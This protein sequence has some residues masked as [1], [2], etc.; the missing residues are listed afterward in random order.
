MEKDLFIYY[1][2]AN[3]KKNKSGNEDF[4][5]PIIIDACLSVMPK[6]PKNFNVDNVRVV[7]IMGASLYDS[8]V[9]NGMVL[10]REPESMFSKF[11]FKKMN[12][13]AVY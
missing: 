9:V 5:A 3:D 1:F 4:L 13:Y 8:R 2:Q 11:F 10:G 6:N 12:N 7:K